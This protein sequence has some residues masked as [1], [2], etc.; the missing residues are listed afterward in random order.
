MNDQHRR[1]TVGRDDDSDDLQFQS[2]VVVTDPAVLGFAA[3]SDADGGLTGTDHVGDPGR[4]ETVLAGRLSQLQPHTPSVQRNHDLFN[5]TRD[6]PFTGSAALCA[7]VASDPVPEARTRS[8]REQSGR[9]IEKLRN[10][11]MAH[12]STSQWLT[13]TR[14]SGSHD[15]GTAALTERHMQDGRRLFGR[16]EASSWAAA[17]SKGDSNEERPRHRPHADR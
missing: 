12:P 2:S 11:A 6:A 3:G 8:C 7:R 13:P 10:G 15:D 9:T 16:E 4:A 17:A 14:N 1:L 5:G